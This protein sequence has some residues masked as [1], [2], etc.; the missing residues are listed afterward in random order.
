MCAAK[1]QA[2]WFGKFLPF[3]NSA[4]TLLFATEFEMFVFFFLLLFGVIATYLENTM[5]ET[6]C[7]T[8]SMGGTTQLDLLS[9]GTNSLERYIH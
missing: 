5:A 7:S 3:T 9:I 8:N 6:N 4:N 1:N 2:K